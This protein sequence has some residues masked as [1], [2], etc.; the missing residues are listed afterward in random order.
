MTTVKE[1]VLATETLVH[2]EYEAARLRA[3][4]FYVRIETTRFGYRVRPMA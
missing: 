3:E 2:A 1:L 4:G